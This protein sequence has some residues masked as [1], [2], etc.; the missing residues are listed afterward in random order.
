MFGIKK[1]DMA[2]A[3]AFVVKKAIPTMR[4]YGRQAVKQAAIINKNMEKEEQQSGFGINVNPS[5]ESDFGGSFGQPS[6]SKKRKSQGV[7]Y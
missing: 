6:K 1:K 3:K 2:K 4:K 5:F 7:F